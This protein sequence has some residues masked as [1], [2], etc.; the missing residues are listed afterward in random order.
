MT[1]ALYGFILVVLSLERLV[2][3][4][5]ARQNTKWSLAQGG[6][7]VAPR[8]YPYMVVIHIGLIVGSFSEVYFLKRPFNQYLFQTMLIISLLCQGLRWWVITT[9]KKQWNTRIIIVPGLSRI[10][11]G[12]YRWLT[13]PNYLAV[14]LEGIAVPMMHS[15]WITALCF[16]ISNL[17]LLS[18]RIYHENSALEQLSPLSDTCSQ[19]A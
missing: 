13:H 14:I 19:G 10:T 18:I 8:H 11:S 6:F 15:A 5:I 2:E 17:L 12:P 1:I 4:I 16:T 7:E 3:L 9:L